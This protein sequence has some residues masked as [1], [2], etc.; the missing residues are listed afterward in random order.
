M[1]NEEELVHALALQQIPQI[2]PVQAR[3][4]I[5][6]FHYFSSIFSSSK[7]VLENIPGIGSIRAK[8][9]LGF[10]DFSSIHE[11][12]SSLKKWQIEPL[13]YT[14]PHYPYRLKHCD[15]AP[16]VLYFR[17]NTDLNHNRIIAIVGTRKPTEQGRQL[18]KSFLQEMISISPLVVSG[19]AYGIDYQVHRVAVD[20]GLP[21]IGVMANGLHTIYPGIH[22]DLAREMIGNGGLLT[23][24]TLG[25]KP[26]KQNFP[27]RNRLVA[28]M[29]D[30]VL[31][32]ETDSKGGSMITAEIA[33]SYNRDVFAVPGRV[34]DIQ[35]RGCHDL[36]REN[37][38]RL[39]VSAHDILAYM[40]W[41]QDVKPEPVQAPLLFA[42][43][44]DAESTLIRSLQE[45]GTMHIDRLMVIS[46][47]PPRDFHQAILN[48]ELEGI[49]KRFSGSHFTLLS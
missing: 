24:F 10:N 8:N 13:I 30:A 5:E 44:S 43:R 12:I 11:Q 37:K 35:S 6:H 20:L 45:Y 33:V 25:T 47:L 42:E 17:G 36:I 1:T 32:M 7:G 4:L 28:G 16:I 41:K 46:G 31:V 29:S 2:G 38:A 3:I 19:L 34:N 21:T 22:S 14:S 49:C 48:L 26:D 27:K 40:N 15:D 9:I 23:E 39:T 18:V